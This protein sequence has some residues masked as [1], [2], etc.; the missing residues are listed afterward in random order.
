MKVKSR[1][2]LLFVLFLSIICAIIYINIIIVS[3]VDNVFEE[4][5][6][7][8]TK[9]QWR[10]HRAVPMLNIDTDADKFVPFFLQ[11]LS[12]W[13]QKLWNDAWVCYTAYHV[14][15]PEDELGTIEIIYYKGKERIEF[16]RYWTGD[17]F[18]EIT[19]AYI[20]S[21][22]L[23]TNELCYGSSETGERDPFLFDILLAKWF[24]YNDETSEFSMENLGDYTDVGM[25]TE[26]Q[27]N[28]SYFGSP[29]FKWRE[30]SETESLST[31]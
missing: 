14:Y 9:E 10:M 13:T 20:Y 7:D 8:R 15:D 30:E 29:Y 19:K 1:I 31:N 23:A 21:Y 2:I 5:Y 12:P 27:W 17:S 25:M 3:N 11:T 24:L 22:D 4:I 26:E 6:Q 16:V 18:S 28:N